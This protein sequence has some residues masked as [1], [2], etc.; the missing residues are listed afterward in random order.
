MRKKQTS[1]ILVFTVIFLAALTSFA[2]KQTDK[3]YEGFVNPPSEVGPDVYWWWNANALSETEISRELD[4][5]KDAGIQGA[6]IFPLQAPLAPTK[7]DDKY[8]QWLSPEWSKM[9]KFTTEAAKKRDMYIDLLV[10]TGWPFGGPSVEDGDGI[11]IIKLA[12]KELAGPGTFKG[13]IKDFMALPPGAYGETTHGSEPEIKF[14]RLL[15]KNPKDFQP[16]IELKDKI[17]PDGSVE[18]EIPAGEH[19]LYTGT[20]REGFIVVNISAPG[21][22]GPVI[23]HLSK[24]A[25]DKYLANFEKALEPYLGKEIGENLRSLHCDSFEFTGANWTADLAQEFEKRRGYSLEPYL[26][27]VIEWPPVSGGPGFNE[28]INKVQYDFWK[29]QKELF[30]ER[31]LTTFYDWCHKQGTECRIEPYGCYATDQVEAKLVPDRPMGETWISMEYEIPK[32]EVLIPVGKERSPRNFGIWSCMSNKYTSSGAHLSGRPNVSCET[33]TSGSGAFCLRLQDIKLGLDTSFM[34]GINHTYYHGYNLSTPQAGYPG[35][36]YCGSYIDEKELWWPY[37]KEVNTYNARVSYVLQKSVSKSQVALISWETFLWEAIHQNGYCVD[38]VNEKILCDA[39]SDRK[40]LIYGLQSYE[41]LIMNRVDAIEPQ[42]AKAIKDF[43]EAGGKIIFIDHAPSYAPGL[44][45]AAERSRQ[46]KETI[47]EI[48]ERYRD[49]I[50]IIPG[51]GQNEW[52]D[53]VTVNIA[54]TGIKP[55]VQISK[56]D[57][58]LYQIHQVKDNKDI[59]FFA[60]LDVVNSKTFTATFDI[61]DKTP[62]RW[63]PITGTRSVMPH[64]GSSIDIKLVPAESLLI[65]FEPDLSEKP[66][67]Q[68]VVYADDY[69][70]IDTPWDLTLKHV[71]GCTSKLTLT[72]LVDF[73]ENPDLAKFS[74]T[75]IYRTEFEISDV[76]R[77]LLSLG[78]IYGISDVTLNGKSLGNRW[79]GEHN[80]DA[81]GVLKAGKNILEVKVVT[82]LSNFFRIWDNPVAKVW[83]QE[84]GNSRDPVSEG[85]VGPVRLI[86]QEK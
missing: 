85:M 57:N 42:T 62:W 55:A 66:A 32:T 36:F 56:P 74:G 3:F 39:K 33:M 31:F 49:R 1:L 35:W 2:S 71:S 21:G 40:K 58:L 22:E 86:R 43:A 10:G 12:K 70:Q 14:L 77:T 76:K 83:T 16:G 7:I 28:I 53:W 54:K 78:T 20:Y 84:K 15:P 4:V 79:W 75:A 59:F 67:Q 51:V 64:N 38:Y 52:L 6:L 80:Y 29:T 45:N 27:F 23:D 18:F 69:F 73:R 46:T 41:I 26:P 17:Q 63:D 9:L 65:I 50:F 48:I 13:N 81:S 61:A 25:L 19:I 34:A 24:P 44:T 82:T 11:K 30:S 47:D 8:L 60:N 5:L 72:A 68:P 37:F